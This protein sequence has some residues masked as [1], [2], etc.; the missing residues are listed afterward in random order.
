MRWSD[1]NDHANGMRDALI[2]IILEWLVLLPVAYYLDHS[3]SVGHKSS[4]L[5]LIK[6]LLKKNPTWRRVSINEVVNDAVHVEMVKQDIIKERET[7][8]QVLQQQSSGYAVVCDDLKKVYHGKDGNPD[9]FAVRGLSLALPYGEC[10][11]ILGPNG[12]GKS[13]FISMM[14]G[15]TRPTSGNAFVREFSIQTDMEKIYNSM[16]VCPQN[17]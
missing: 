15:L 17:E 9:K 4:F 6:N 16:G 11:G 2:I 1:L 8:D 3:A 7:V 14:I 10:L 13:S 5:S 12:A